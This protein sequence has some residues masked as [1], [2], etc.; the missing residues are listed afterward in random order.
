MV[1]YDSMKRHTGWF[2]ALGVA[3]I[4]L[5]MIAIVMAVAATLISVMAFGWLLLIG[6]IF[7][8]VHAW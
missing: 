8:L 4:V 7:E 3:L 1:A 5:G 6:G 2:T